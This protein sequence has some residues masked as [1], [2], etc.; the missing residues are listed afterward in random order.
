MQASGSSKEKTAGVSGANQIVEG[1]LQAWEGYRLK[2][3]D[4]G[5]SGAV[6]NRAEG[7][8]TPE[9]ARWIGEAGRNRL[10][11]GLLLHTTRKNAALP[12]NKDSFAATFAMGCSE[13]S[14]P[15]AKRFAANF[16]V[17]ESLSSLFS[18][19][20]TDISPYGADPVFLRRS[21]LYQPTL[22][23]SEGDFY[24]VS[25]QGEVPVATGVPYGYFHRNLKVGV[26]G[27]S[28]Q[29]LAGTPLML[30]KTFMV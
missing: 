18:G 14:I 4:V 23:G 30:L 15:L 13:A 28:H 10:V 2:A 7:L 1:E 9:R 21:S 12:C 25:D 11:G 29:G 20:N 3:E 26:K 5:S 8:D 24:N 17:I 22:S 16:S 27:T 6:W 19:A